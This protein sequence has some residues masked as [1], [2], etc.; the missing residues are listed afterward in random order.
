MNE[1]FIFWL[2]EKYLS[3]GVVGSR[4]NKEYCDLN[5]FSEKYRYI[6][7]CYSDLEV[8]LPI[9]VFQLIF[10][11]IFM[12]AIMMILFKGV[13][14]WSCQV[15]ACNYCRAARAWFMFRCMLSCWSCQVFACNYCRAWF[16][17]QA[18]LDS[19]LNIL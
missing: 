19:H 14:N 9:K 11:L 16:I 1:I 2:A 5:I 6:F 18:M 7:L 12:Y 3:Y 17:S 15:F 13:E 4:D 8:F 10:C